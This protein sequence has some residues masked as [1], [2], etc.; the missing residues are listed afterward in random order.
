MD[1]IDA[2]GAEDLVKPGDELRV[3]VADQERDVLERPGEA[4]VAGL[5]RDPLVVRVGDRACQVHAAGLKLD[6]EQHVVAAPQRSFDGEEVTGDDA[7]GLDAQELAPR[8]SRVPRR[9]AQTGAHEHP[10][11]VLGETDRPSLSSS[12]AIR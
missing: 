3:V 1:Q 2:F 11:T 5:L 12:P 8:R 4:E 6:E 7:R 10:A 9:R